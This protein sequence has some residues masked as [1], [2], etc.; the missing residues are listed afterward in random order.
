MCIQ[1][2]TFLKYLATGLHFYAVRLWHPFNNNER[3]FQLADANIITFS[4]IFSD[5]IILRPSFLSANQTQ[6]AI[7]NDQLDYLHE[8]NSNSICTSFRPLPYRM[9]QRWE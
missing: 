9:C 4:C 3:Q 7:N 1:S 5:M 6:I 8:K 2:G